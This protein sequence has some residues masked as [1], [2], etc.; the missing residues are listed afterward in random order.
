MTRTEGPDEQSTSCMDRASYSLHRPPSPVQTLQ[1]DQT[2]LQQQRQQ[3]KSE[4]AASNEH[5]DEY[6]DDKGR[7]QNDRGSPDSSKQSHQ[8][9]VIPD[10]APSR[11][12]DPKYEQK[13]AK[14]TIED[15][16]KRQVTDPVTHLEVMIHDFTSKELKH[17]LKNI[18]L[19]GSQQLPVSDAEKSRSEI[20][21]DK[22]HVGME[23][24][25]PPG[26]EYAKVELIKTVRFAVNAGMGI[27]LL[28]MIPVLVDKLFNISKKLWSSNGISRSPWADA[29]LAT[30]TLEAVVLGFGLWCFRC[31][32]ENKVNSFWEDQVWEGERKSGREKASSYTPESTQW[33]N[34][35]LA[36]I[37]PLVNP[38][39]FASL[40]D[41]LEDSMQANLPTLV[42]MV[43]VEDLGQGNEA[44]RILGIRWLPSDETAHSHGNSNSLQQDQTHEHNIKKRPQEEKEE[45]VIKAVEAEEGETVSLQIAFPYRARPAARKLSS[46]A[47]NAHLFLAIYLPEGIRLP[48]WVEMK[49]IVGTIR[50]RFQLTPDPPF[51]A[52]CTFTFMGKPKANLSCMP[53]FRHGLNIMNLPVISSFIQTSVDAAMA[54]YVAPK[55]L[56]LD[57]KDI[58][59]ADDFKTDTNAYGVIVVRIKR[60]IS[61]KE[62]DTG[63]F[64]M[65]K[66]CTDP[67]I[68]S[69][70]EPIW[71][72]TCFVVVSAKEFNAEEKLRM[73]LRDHNRFA[74]DS[75]LGCIDVELK[76]V[77][78]DPRTNGKMLD[79]RDTLHTLRADGDMP[80][81]LDWSLGYFSK[82]RVL[83]SQLAQQTDDQEIK[84]IDDL[85]KKVEKESAKKLR[86]PRKDESHEIEQQEAQGLKDREDRIIISTPPSAD[87]PSGIFA[88]QIHQ[89]LSLGFRKEKYNPGGVNCDDDDQVDYDDLLSSYCSVIL[90]HKRVFKTRTKP[91]SAKPSFNTGTEQFI[92]DWRTTEVM[93]SVRDLSA[94]EHDPLVGVVVLSLA[95]IFKQRSQIDDYFLLSGG[96]G[97]GRV[98]ISM[99]FRSIQLL[100]PKELRGWKYGT[101]KI[102][103]DI[104]SKDL[105]DHYKG[106]GLKLHTSTQTDEMGKHLDGWS[107]H[108]GQPVDL[109]VK[110]RY[111]SSLLVEFQGSNPIHRHIS[112]FSIV[113]LREIPDNEEK[114]VTLPVWKGNSKRAEV[115]NE[116]ESGEQLGHI[117]MR[118]RFQPG[119]SDR[120]NKLVSKD[121]NLGDVMEIL[122]TLKHNKIKI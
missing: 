72:E 2:Q 31:W 76:E 1:R 107:G 60:A 78:Q 106:L 113:W 105:A 11:E 75:D 7:F 84:T 80:C 112:A 33:L 67:M 56:T 55:S 61:F 23:R 99:M 6:E 58:F 108:Q 52:R 49:G 65:K 53:L 18:P 26:R 25:F 29:V 34:S 63:L 10:T 83:P 37:W 3:H 21:S 119:I 68:L 44:L 48:V 38:D 90:N 115:D 94:H 50:L 86:E 109:A 73:Q 95:E 35:L 121:R 17:A 102:T 59:M 97:Q 82:R 45:N 88:I 43:T 64:G 74:A 36:S 24:S 85:R 51:F 15:Y 66:R 110:Q 111:S 96:I 93:L 79:R 39:L 77:M 22:V 120:H 116:L 4:A 104:K 122:G 114:T 91:K 101:L 62:S 57:L 71:D 98:H 89:I 16:A 42:N 92:R 9:Q 46:K 28:T 27:L 20:Q 54:K 70:M 32:I 41:P 103:S 81:T 19:T 47:K 12:Q 5:M 8:S 14:H 13:I 30:I 40:A 69:E 118:L 100:L 87:Y 117:E